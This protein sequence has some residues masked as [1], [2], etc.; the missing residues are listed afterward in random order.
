MIPTRMLAAAMMLAAA[1]A[2]AQAQISD[3]KL[4]LG[5][6]TDLSGPYSDI[7]GKSS[8]EAIKMAIEDFGGSVLDAP[9]EHIVTDHQNKAD[10]ASKQVREWISERKLDALVDVVT[11][12][13]A[14]ASQRLGNENN[15]L[16]MYSG[17]GTT[18]LINSGCSP[19]SFLWTYD[20]YAMATG[21]GAGIAKGGGKK[22]FIITA[23]YAFG[24]QLEKNVSEQVKK[25]GG[26]VV[27]TVRHPFNNAD[28]SSFLL[29]AK[30]SGADIIGL[31]SAGND[32]V[33]M[34]KQA[35]EFGI[36]RGGQKLV[37]LLLFIN[38]LDGIGL[39][40]AQDLVT[41]I[42]FYWDRTPEARAWSE[43]FHKRYGKMPNM[44]NAGAYS[45]TMH[46]LKAVKAA[47]TDE[48]KK[49]ADKMRELPIEDFFAVNPKLRVDGRMVH[50]M[51]LAQ[52][53]KPAESKGRWDYYKVLDT[54]PGDQAFPPLEISTC[55]LVKK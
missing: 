17:S 55:S 37:A 34:I 2:A 31:A 12:P 41:T 7:A 26:E 6:A 35:Q 38:D 4:V 8:V 33:N 29:Q 39:E 18:E 14:L 15:I 42:G 24:H 43:R 11:T 49:V 47:G 32:L 19:I 5:T 48:S 21:T 36:S 27:G 28:F 51:W 53:K 30:A 54:I 16:S 1:S 9:I 45:M 40:A 13:A 46:Y 23:D 3:G 25:Q 44:M 20:T 52:V 10:I 22:W 50:D